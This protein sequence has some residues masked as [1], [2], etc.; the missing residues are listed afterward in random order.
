MFP[1]MVSHERLNASQNTS[2]TWILTS[3]IWITWTRVRGRFCSRR[4]LPTFRWLSRCKCPFRLLSEPKQSRWHIPGIEINHIRTTMFRLCTF[5]SPIVTWSC[6][7]PFEHG[8]GGSCHSTFFRFEHEF[9]K[10][11]LET[12]NSRQLHRRLSTETDVTDLPWMW[13]VNRPN[14]RLT[15]RVH[16]DSPISIFL[17]TSFQ[18]LVSRVP[19]SFPIDATKCI[20]KCTFVTCTRV[21][22]WNIHCSL[23]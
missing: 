12:T 7:K 5:V 19:S 1:K 22:P 23:F 16:S 3:G 21:L 6:W 2:K 17:Q 13:L 11:M 14:N 8:F 18:T 4:R 9:K 15:E 10:K 20:R